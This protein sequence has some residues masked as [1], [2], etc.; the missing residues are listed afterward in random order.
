M[1]KTKRALQLTSAILSIVAGSIFVVACFYI[2]AF[3]PMLLEQIVGS[4]YVGYAG[5][6]LALIYA[7]VI[8]CM[9]FSV[10]MIVVGACACP[11]RSKRKT[12]SE[13]TG[14][15]ITLL[16]LNGVSF[17]FSLIGGSV[18]WILISL[19]IIGLCVAV[20]CI[21]S[22]KITPASAGQV[23]GSA[24]SLGV[25]KTSAPSLQAQT[26]SAKIAKIRELN[27]QGVLS[28]QEMKE[29]IIQELNKD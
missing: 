14:Y 25:E 23:Q 24:D 4:E 1:N 26:S 17:L 3:A 28:D 12:P 27:A 15:T 29:L 18:L 10:A 21:P 16:I 5:E 13:N 22:E 2:L 6:A 9:C 11:N 7:G 20:L 8:L 19:I